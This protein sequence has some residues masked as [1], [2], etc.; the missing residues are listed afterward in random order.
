MTAEHYHAD[1]E[2]GDHVVNPSEDALFMRITDL[3]TDD[4]TF[5][6]IEPPGDDPA[7]YAVVSLLEDGVYE[8]ERSYPHRRLHELTTETDRSEIAR[9]LTIWLA[10][11]GRIT[12]QSSTGSDL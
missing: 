9:D 12:R 8:V 5:L 11:A 1:S 7:W 6:T 2:N 3:N 10:W 4:N